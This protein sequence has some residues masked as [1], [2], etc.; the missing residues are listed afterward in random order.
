MGWLDLTSNSDSLVPRSHLW[1]DKVLDSS[2]RD[3][4]A[5]LGRTQFLRLP[6]ATNAASTNFSKKNLS[7]AMDVTSCLIVYHPNFIPGLIE[8]VYVCLEMGVWDGVWESLKKLE[9]AVPPDGG[10]D[11]VAVGSLLEICRDGGNGNGSTNLLGRSKNTM[12][13]LVSNVASVSSENI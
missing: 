3:L 2:P 13:G 12:A 9:S 6:S 8:R 10:I 7:V 4:D 5:L 11:A 1:F